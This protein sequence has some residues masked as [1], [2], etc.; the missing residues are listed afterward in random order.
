MKVQIKVRSSITTDYKSNPAA[1]ALIKCKNIGC[2]E[3]R[4]RLLRYEKCIDELIKYYDKNEPN[5]NTID[6]FHF[7]INLRIGSEDEDD[8]NTKNDS[9]IKNYIKDIKDQWVFQ[10]CDKIETTQNIRI[11]K[12]IAEIKNEKIS[13]VHLRFLFAFLENAIKIVFT[14]CILTFKKINNFEKVNSNL[15][16]K[17][18]HLVF[19]KWTYESSA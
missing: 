9:W 18:R 12:F 14:N 8:F 15:K 7:K 6:F 11:Y 10:F 19:D 4:Q 3:S 2:W 1:F 5:S 13:F 17:T 16:W